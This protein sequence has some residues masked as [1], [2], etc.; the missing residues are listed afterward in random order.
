MGTCDAS[1]VRRWSLL[2]GGVSDGPG[3]TQRAHTLAQVSR[4]YHLGVGADLG[5]AYCVIRHVGDL[6]PDPVAIVF[7][8]TEDAPNYRMHPSPRS[9]LL[10][11]FHPLGA[12]R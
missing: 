9:D 10:I 12:G 4:L 7:F 6:S 11:S 2:G 5:L 1:R 8:I 3:S